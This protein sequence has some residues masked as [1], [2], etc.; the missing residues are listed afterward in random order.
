MIYITEEDVRRL[1]SMDRAIKSIEKAFHELGTGSGNNIPRSRVQLPNQTLHVMSA[2]STEL[3][4][5]GKIG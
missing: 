4:A 2:G 3:T 1:L 5:V